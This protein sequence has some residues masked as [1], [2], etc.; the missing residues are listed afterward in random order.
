V[1]AS[2]QARVWEQFYRGTAA[3]GVAPGMGVGLAVVKA[4]TEAQGG[5]VGLSSAAG[6]GSCFW[7]E[8][9]TAGPRP[10]SGETE[11]RAA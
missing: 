6:R 5:R 4:L 9:P 10:D 7:L 8:L 3:A 11:D 2:E 1:P